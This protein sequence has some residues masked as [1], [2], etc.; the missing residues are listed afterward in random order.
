MPSTE[1]GSSSKRLLILVP[2][3]R[4]LTLALS[5]A[6]VYKEMPSLTLLV[7]NLENRVAIVIGRGIIKGLLNYLIIIKEALEEQ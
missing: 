5:I 1:K 2:L 7:I 6:I 3:L 4:A